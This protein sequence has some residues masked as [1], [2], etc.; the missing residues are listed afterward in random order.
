MPARGCGPDPEAEREDVDGSSDQGVE[1]NEVQE[2]VEEEY[3][4]EPK[5]HVHEEV[6]D[7]T[8]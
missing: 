8:M 3:G 2:V 6:H 4:C 1:G 7:V 5:K